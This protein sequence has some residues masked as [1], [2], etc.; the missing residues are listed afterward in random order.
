M[1]DAQREMER[2]RGD[3]RVKEEALSHAKEKWEELTVSAEDQ[4]EAEKEIAEEIAGAKEE[5][6]C[7]EASLQ[8]A[9]E[10]VSAKEAE[11]ESLSRA[12]AEAETAYVRALALSQEKEKEKEK[13]SQQLVPCKRRHRASGGGDRS[14]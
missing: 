9:K 14:S 12:L 7:A 2:L 3:Y 8:A 5:L 10:A 6:S 4:T 13:V 1:A 11:K